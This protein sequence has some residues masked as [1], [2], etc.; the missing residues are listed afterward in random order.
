EPIVWVLHLGYAWI[1]AGLALSALS[2]FTGLV[3]SALVSHAFGTGAIGTMI[4]AVMS[5]ASL[6]HTGRRLIAPR[7]IVWAYHLVTLAAVLRVAGPL[8]APQHDAAI[9]AA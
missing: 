7:S 3:P 2:A 9:L 5:R 8:L 1:V 4:I 6:G